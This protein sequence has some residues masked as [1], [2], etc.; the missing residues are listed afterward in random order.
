MK[1]EFNMLGPLVKGKAS[2]NND[3]YLAITTHRES[4]SRGGSLG[5]VVVGDDRVEFDI[6]DRSIRVMHSGDS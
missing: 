6:M 2:I 3:S 5:V 4:S 1:I